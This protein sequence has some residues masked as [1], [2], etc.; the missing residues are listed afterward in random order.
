MITK[1]TKCN[2]GKVEYLSELHMIPNTNPQEAGFEGICLNCSAHYYHKF[3]QYETEITE[4]DDFL[5][6]QDKEITNP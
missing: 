4:L 1:C 3:K 5:E 2:K 6:E